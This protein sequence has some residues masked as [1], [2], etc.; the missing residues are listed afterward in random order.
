M[1][2]KPY[3]NKDIRLLKGPIPLTIFNKVWKNAAILYHSEKC[4]KS[5][6]VATDQNRYTG[7]PY[8]SNWT[9]TFSEWTT[10]HQ[11]FYQ[12]LVPKYNFKKF[13]KRL[14]SITTL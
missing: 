10:N 5:D 11:G 8:P 7:F 6:D 2:F 12:T 13:G 14:K 9:Q 4:T 1:G 3:F